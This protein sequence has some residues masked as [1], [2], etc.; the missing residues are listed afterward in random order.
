MSAYVNACMYIIYLGKVY[1]LILVLNWQD[2]LSENNNQ[3]SQNIK[4]FITNPRI[5][6]VRVKYMFLEM[7]NL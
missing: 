3:L 4:A 6:H 2:V 1:I 7:G 5:L